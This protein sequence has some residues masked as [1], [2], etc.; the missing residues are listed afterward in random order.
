MDVFTKPDQNSRR[1]D[2]TKEEQQATIAGLLEE[3]KGYVVRVLDA[4]EHADAE[5]AK[6]MND[7]VAQVD[8]ELK[9]LG[10][11]A[12]KPSKRASSRPA[13]RQASKR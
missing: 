2:V 5:R 8:A 3:R 6:A 9:R 1:R 10:A 11:S 13:Q 12:E 7:R 4:E